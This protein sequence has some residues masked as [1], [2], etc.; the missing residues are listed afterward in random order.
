MKRLCAV[1]F[2]LA[3][4]GL[5][6]GCGVSNSS[7]SGNGN[8]GGNGGGSTPQPQGV[9]IVGED[10]PIPTVV[11]FN[12]TI[13]KI[14]LNNN[15]G[16]VTVLSTP[17]TVDFG[18]LIGL[19]SLLGFNQVT[20]GTYTTATFSL[21][22]PVI[23]YINLGTNPPSL[24]TIN[25]TL[26]NPTVTVA[27]PTAM[28][29]TSAQLGGLHMDFNLRK[30]LQT[31]VAGQMTG[32]VNPTIYIN[33]VSASSQE[34]QVTEFT[35]SLVSVNSQASTFLM[36]GPWG[37]QEVIDVNSETQFNGSYNFGS[38]PAS[39]IVS[40]V[41]AVQDDG[42]ILAS[43]VEIITTDKAFISGRVLQVV[44]SAGPA[45]TMTM[46]IG[47]ELPA[48]SGN[49]A[50][51][52]VVT[53]DIS[54]ISNYDVCFL[55]NP[56]TNAVFNSSEMVAGQRIFV[57]G[58]WQSSVFTPKMISL[59]RQG[60]VGQLVAGS[61][62]VTDINRGSFELHNNGLL[63]WVASGP[64]TVN[65][66]NRTNF[67]NV[68]GLSGLSSAGTAAISTGGLVLNVNGEPQV[69]AGHVTILP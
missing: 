10:A 36:Q 22:S 18:R 37:F 54:Q 25:G 63:G 34:G 47:E 29:V 48:M 66:F 43:Q 33:A 67:V 15:S 23:E 62:K 45:Q 50:R 40:V 28:V 16:S 2:M 53:L 51:G 61:V 49:F 44:P 7:N 42:S 5:A 26:T 56:I 46:Y 3:L 58:S 11:D 17:T 57:G 19:R 4:A 31:N 14:T 69:F 9:F 35:G 32:V 21:A 65:T 1:T 8:N 12:I 39:G 41:G 30:S 24:G 20:P 59:R 64:F 6:I 68:D 13:N 38:M 55:N 60:V 27:F 52:Q